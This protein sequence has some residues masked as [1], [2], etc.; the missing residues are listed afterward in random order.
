[1]TQPIRRRG[2]TEQAAAAAI[3]TACR[4]LRLPTVRDLVTDLV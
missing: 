4:Q 1:M 3:D 2:S